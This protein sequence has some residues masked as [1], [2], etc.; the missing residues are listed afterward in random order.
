MHTGTLIYSDHNPWDQ[1][2]RIARFMAEDSFNRGINPLSY[3]NSYAEKCC[4]SILFCAL[5]VAARFAN[6]ILCCILLTSLA[7]LP[8]AAGGMTSCVQ[9]ILCLLKN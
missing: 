4:C 9:P 8:P 5:T 1:N 7:G 3:R 2:C 6:F